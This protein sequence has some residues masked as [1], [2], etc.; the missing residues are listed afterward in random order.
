MLKAFD[1]WTGEIGCSR[2][3]TCHPGATSI[4]EEKI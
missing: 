1:I 3:R 4:G 2:E